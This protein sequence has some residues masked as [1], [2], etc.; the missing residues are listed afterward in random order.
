MVAPDTIR[1]REGAEVDSVGAINT[2]I[3]T[4]IVLAN[5]VLANDTV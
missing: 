2:N 1:G 5:T 3:G 4:S